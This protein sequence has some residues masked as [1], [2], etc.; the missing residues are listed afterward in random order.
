MQCGEDLSCTAHLLL[1]QQQRQLLLGVHAQRKPTCSSLAEGTGKFNCVVPLKCSSA[2]LEVCMGFRSVWFWNS[3]L[4][5]VNG[6]TFCLLVMLGNP[7]CDV[8]VASVG[9]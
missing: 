5:M 4:G 2:E 9:L 7:V 3:S 6:P 1:Q 8:S